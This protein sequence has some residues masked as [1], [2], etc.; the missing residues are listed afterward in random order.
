MH[1][2]IDFTVDCN[3]VYWKQG[4]IGHKKENKD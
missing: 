3:I 2:I 4:R 1:F